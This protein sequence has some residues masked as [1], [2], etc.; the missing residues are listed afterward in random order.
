MIRIAPA[1]P[2]LAL[3][4]CNSEPKDLLEAGLYCKDYD[5][6]CDDAIAYAPNYELWSDGADKE[7][8]LVL[9]KPIDTSNPDFWESPNGT[10]AFKTFLV[11][12]IPVETRML[13]K[14]D[15]NW[16]YTTYR[17]NGAGTEA[18]KRKGGKKDALETGH[19]VPRRGLCDDCHDGASDTL[20]GISAVQLYHAGGVMDLHQ[21]EVDGTVSDVIPRGPTVLDDPILG[22]GLGYLHA[23]CGTCHYSDFLDLTVPSG[24]GDIAFT[25]F[26]QTAWDVKSDNDIEGA[27]HYAAIGNPKNSEIWQRMKLR[28]KNQMPPITTDRVDKNGTDLVAALIEGLAPGAIATQ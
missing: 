11:D 14:D 28:G 22:P 12:D 3:F 23:N 25:G 7:R 5:T 20:L 19:N 24:A 4:A 13:H 17:W 8:Y 9:P 10:K 1:L 18:T 26:Y 2:F 27:T 21:L 15:G 16:S 6:I